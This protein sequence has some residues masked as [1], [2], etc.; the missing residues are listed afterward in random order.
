MVQAVPGLE[1]H[2]A[3]PMRQGQVTELKD[4]VCASAEEAREASEEAG[5]GQH[6]N[7]GKPSYP[8]QW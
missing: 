4:D 8:V 5:P 3:V 1:A 7:L 2:Y 6:C